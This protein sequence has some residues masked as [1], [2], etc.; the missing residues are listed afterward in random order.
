MGEYQR[1]NLHTRNSLLLQS[2]Y[3]FPRTFEKSNYNMSI[4]ESNINSAS[5]QNTAFGINSNHIPN[6]TCQ[7][8]SNTEFKESRSPKISLF[9]RIIEL[10]SMDDE[11]QA[12]NQ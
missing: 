5:T 3:E 12:V 10:N 4:A 2:S 9:D 7:Q 6:S 1:E 11:Y 8:S